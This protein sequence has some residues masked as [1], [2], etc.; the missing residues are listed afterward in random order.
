MIELRDRTVN[1]LRRWVLR[2]WESR[3]GGFYGFVAAL[4]FVYLE[5]IDLAGDAVDLAGA[6][7][8]AGYI[9]GFVVGNLVDALVNGLR[10]AIWPVSWIGNFGAG[11]LSGALL[12][13]SYATYRAIRPSVLR[14]LTPTDDQPAPIVRPA[15]Q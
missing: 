12:L 2:V 4:T 10:A 15:A 5:I 9:I 13:G 7:M 8:S 11:M 3:G 6:P 14:L 1:W